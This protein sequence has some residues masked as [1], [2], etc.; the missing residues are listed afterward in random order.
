[1]TISIHE[2]EEKDDSIFKSI[3]R[4]FLISV[5]QEYQ[6]MS[7]CT[8]FSGGKNGL[9]INCAED[10]TK[11]RKRCRCS[12]H[13]VARRYGNT[14]SNDVAK[15]TSICLH[16]SDDCK[17]KNRGVTSRKLNLNIVSLCFD[18]PNN[19][20]VAPEARNYFDNVKRFRV[21]EEK[22]RLQRHQEALQ[23]QQE[24]SQKLRIQEAILRL[25]RESDSL[26]SGIRLTKL[27]DC[28]SDCAKLELL[29]KWEEQDN[30]RRENGI[31][32]KRSHEDHISHQSQYEVFAFP[33]TA[34]ILPKLVYAFPTVDT[35]STL[36]RIDSI[37]TKTSHYNVTLVLTT[38]TSTPIS[39]MRQSNESASPDG[40]YHIQ[41]DVEWGN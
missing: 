7:T 21:A 4:I 29:S 24:A 12:L 18:S 15:I 37:S 33:T 2:E 22:K 25:Q 5:F 6:V 17:L 8:V 9:Q 38:S 16:H 14:N 11:G 13:I 1:M 20:Q 19:V 31:L 26:Y 30:T 40:H 10:G 35:Q 28:V 3:K 41:D 39:S 36:K 27:N 34:S 23:C 32:R